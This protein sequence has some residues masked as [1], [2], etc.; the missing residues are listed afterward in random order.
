MVP[1]SLVLAAVLALPLPALGAQ[2]ASVGHW[3]DTVGDIGRRYGHVAVGLR[4]GRV[5]VA[6]GL[7]DTRHGVL[8]S[9]ALFDPSR[10]VTPA[11]PMN[12]AR[13][14]P[15]TAL[16]GDGSVLVTGGE[17]GDRSTDRYFPALDRWIPMASMA[18][19]RW[20]H[21]A[22][23]LRDG[24]VLVAGGE[25]VAGCCEY[26]AHADTEIYNPVSNAW[27][28]G[29]A[30]RTARYSHTATLLDDGRVLVVGGNGGARVGQLASAEIFDPARGAWNAAPEMSVARVEHTATLLRD[31]RVLIAGGVRDETY[32]ATSEIF[33]P[34]A[35][36]WARTGEMSV[37]RAGHTATP[38]DDGKVLVAGGL[39]RYSDPLPTA[40][41]Y[42]PETGSWDEAIPM[43]APRYL[44]TATLLADRQRV[45]FIG[46]WNR[47]TGA[48]GDIALYQR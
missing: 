5:L 24:R 19:P 18:S 36:Q 31:G 10:G 44:H 6:G 28:A 39:F 21:S 17:G 32:W 23:V 47:Q 15:A 9:T 37:A 22:T 13:Y 30:M 46:G 1:V 43:K 29:P 34:K 48:T 41:I 3:H 25:N 12:A 7:D 8:S 14:R 42:D 11:A 4:D 20:G 33:D 26:T 35:A 16:L 2:S 38:W 45:A 27:T 40:E